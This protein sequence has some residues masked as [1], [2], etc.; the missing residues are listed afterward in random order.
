MVEPTWYTLPDYLIERF[1]AF[2]AEIEDSYFDWLTT[3]ADPYPHFFLEEFLVPLLVGRGPM[4]DVETRMEAGRVLDQLLTSPDTDLAAA[5]LTSIVEMLRDE[6]QLRSAAWPILGPTA[7]KW[8]F[9]LSAE[10]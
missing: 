8:L 1:P 2:K 10:P 4:T 5:A 7:R 3:I 6:A 9:D